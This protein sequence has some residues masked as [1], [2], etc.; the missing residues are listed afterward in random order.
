MIPSLEQ[1]HSAGHRLTPMGGGGDG[2]SSAAE[3]YTAM[4]NVKMSEEQLKWAKD[5]YEQERPAREEAADDE[6]AYAL[7]IRP[8]RPVV[9]VERLRTADGT[10]MAYEVGHY[11]AALFPGLLD[12]EL[13]SR[14]G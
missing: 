11:P 12:R 4:A 5:I 10:P 9:R 3:Q 1:R 6:V 13:G 7:R 14:E 8:T 2:G